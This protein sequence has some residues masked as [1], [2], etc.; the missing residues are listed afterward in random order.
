MVDKE[1]SVVIPVFK[2]KEALKPLYQHLKSTLD[3]LG[4]PWEVIFINDACPEGSGSILR[5]LTS[6]DSR[7]IVLEL[8][9]NVGQ[10][11]ATWIGLHAVRGK[12]VVVLDADLQDPPE[13]IPSLLEAIKQDLGKTFIVFAG[14]RG[15]YESPHRL[16]TSR[17]FKYTLHFLCGI[18]KD[19]GGYYLMNRQ[20]VENLLRWDI[21]NPYLPAMIGSTKL[22][23]RSI[24]IPRKKRILGSSSYTTIMRLKLGLRA[25]W[26]AWNLKWNPS[27][28]MR[29]VDQI[30][31][32]PDIRQMGG[33]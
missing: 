1:L 7:I 33:G 19:A 3:S 13:A 22:P 24:P 20:V 29:S 18:P 12:Y 25:L 15:R 2:S 28:F 14:R 26:L 6:K 4:L 30:N 17:I 8:P 16:L 27:K 9:Q 10:N 31:I 21:P 11:R 23:S 5:E 32:P